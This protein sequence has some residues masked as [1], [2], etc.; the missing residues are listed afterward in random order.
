MGVIPGKRCGGR[1]GGGEFEIDL[2]QDSPVSIKDLFMEL[3]VSWE[4]A[5]RDA[6]MGDDDL[7]WSDEESD[8][9]GDSISDE[10]DLLMSDGVGPEGSLQAAKQV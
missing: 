9:S 1:C 7:G 3:K 2:P 5:R 4:S 8:F 10:D 6:L